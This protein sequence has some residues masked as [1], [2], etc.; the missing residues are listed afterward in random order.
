MKNLITFAMIAAVI[1]VLYK[2]AASQQTTTAP[3]ISPAASP[4]NPEMKG[5]PYSETNKNKE[6][7]PVSASSLLA[8]N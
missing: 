7:K 2:V 6:K 8:I 4:A 1:Y 3:A 5:K